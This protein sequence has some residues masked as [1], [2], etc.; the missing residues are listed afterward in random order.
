[1]VK[2]G[3]IR[4]DGRVFWG[5]NKSSQN[6]E[7]WCSY[8]SF[9]R[10][11][12]KS[13]ARQWMNRRRRTHWLNKYKEH[14]GCCHCGYD[15]DGVALQFHHLGN[16]VINISDARSSSLKKLFNELRKCVVMCANC[17]AI[18]TTRLQQARSK[19]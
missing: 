7:E 6:G 12:S 8:A 10:R 5:Y 2:H 11:K 9:V 13:R 3:T 18:E 17:H 19:I 4:E 14:E 15:E 1:M 16:K